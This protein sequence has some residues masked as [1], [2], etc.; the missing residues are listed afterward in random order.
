[1]RQHLEHVEALRSEI[2]EV[3][4]ERCPVGWHYFLVFVPANAEP[5]APCAYHTNAFT[6]EELVVALR[7]AAEGLE[8][9]DLHIED[10]FSESP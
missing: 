9:P 10:P 6:V 7:A 8:D 4:S 5:L 3:L 1:M 2:G